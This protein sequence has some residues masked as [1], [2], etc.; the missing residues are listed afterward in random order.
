MTDIVSLTFANSPPTA[1]TPAKAAKGKSG[2]PFQQLLEGKSAAAKKPALKK[3]EENAQEGVIPMA[4]PVF[5]QPVVKPDMPEVEGNPAPQGLA[6]VGPQ[7]SQKAVAESG[8]SLD[9]AG[10]MVKAA[11]PGIPGEGMLA[12][13]AQTT[14]EGEAMQSHLQ[15]EAP[16]LVGEAAAQQA[17]T[18]PEIQPSMMQGES[19]QPVEVEQIVKKPEI[20]PKMEAK[21]AEETSVKLENTAV[22]AN[23]NAQSDT[24]VEMHAQGS[25]NAAVEVEQ[26]QVSKKSQVETELDV[27]THMSAGAAEGKAAQFLTTATETAGV[28][29]TKAMQVV[30]QVQDKVRAAVNSGT[31]EVSFT[32]H[33]KDLGEV[34]VH[35]SYGKEGVGVTLQAGSSST[36][37][38]LES[39][40]SQ[41][42]QN[43][44][45]SGIN[46]SDLHVGHGNQQQ[47]QGST[48]GQ[49]QQNNPNPWQ[50]NSRLQQDTP[51]DSILELRRSMN[52][53]VQVDYLA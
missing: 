38:V 8:E 49:Q 23:P 43:L 26:V 2:T 51:L 20:A 9:L 42:R 32:L 50:A 53:D 39:Q 46:L 19:A 22:P 33:P 45:D 7:A 27:R 15:G 48:Y 31:T 18:A 30:E 12:A 47:H 1:G 40:L 29:N 36:S 16:T 37:Q 35:L 28:S 5:S 44:V 25:E 17:E 21:A 10:Q 52:P 34:S 4:I 13:A 41:L 14:A 6:G 11:K 3:D 24:A